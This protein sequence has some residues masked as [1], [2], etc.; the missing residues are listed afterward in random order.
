MKHKILPGLLLSTVFMVACAGQEMA[1]AGDPAKDLFE[2]KC[3]SCHSTQR[4]KSAKKTK[5]GWE[6]TV[7]R[8][9]KVRGA[10]IND[11]EAEIIIDYLTKN[12]GK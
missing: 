10:S 1:Q 2:S 4:P 9:M 8:M 12:Y 5:E 7:I 6:E 3:S 11:E